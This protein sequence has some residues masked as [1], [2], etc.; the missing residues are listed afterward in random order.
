MELIQGLKECWS[1]LSR[2]DRAEKAEKVPKRLKVQ[3]V[4]AMFEFLADE[5]EVG[6]STRS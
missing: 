6:W 3:E 5:G 1:G 2:E 4:V